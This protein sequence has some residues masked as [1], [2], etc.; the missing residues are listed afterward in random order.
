MTA[1]SGITRISETQAAAGSRPSLSF[2]CPVDVAGLPEAGLDLMLRALL[3]ILEDLDSEKSVLESGQRAL[4][5][6]LEDSSAEAV[7]LE[8][9]QKAALNILED[10]AAEK[11]RIADANRAFLNILDDSATERGRL[12]DAQRAALNILED[13]DHE[14]TRVEQMNEQ[15]GREVRERSLVQE[16]LVAANSELEAFTYSVAH[17]LRAPL[18]SIDGFGQALLEDYSGKLDAQGQ[19]NLQRVRAGAQRMA[20][21]IDG[22]LTLSR[23]TRADLHREKVD[24]SKMAMAIFK[25][26]Q[27][28]EPDRRLEITIAA[29]LVTQGD[30]RLLQ[31]ALEN[32][33]GNAWKF[34]RRKTQARIEFGR[35]ERAVQNGAFFVRDD[36]DGFDMAYADKLFAPFQ[37]LHRQSEF[38]G[39]GIGLATVQRI[40]YR[41]G[42]RIWAEGAVGQGATFY[43]TL[44][45]AEG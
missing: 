24:L 18:R 8:E 13:F 22:L 27:R 23:V 6:I 12:E 38:P 19:D 3:N 4:L 37:R 9:S 40:V 17:D 35:T 1:M 2:S 32:L 10:S 33:L 15:L 26:L 41:H 7:Q 44:P 5:N 28:S 31:A 11:D 42:G 45:A 16:Q 43:F 39:T 36:G 20:E 29:G 25:D 34:T 14:R 30:G 21:L